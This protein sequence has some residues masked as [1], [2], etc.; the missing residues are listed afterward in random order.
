VLFEGRLKHTR[1]GEND[2]TLVVSGF[3][4]T[5]VFAPTPALTGSN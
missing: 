3:E 5:P 2:W 1:K 4:I